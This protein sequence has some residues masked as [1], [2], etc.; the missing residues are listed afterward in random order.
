[1]QNELSAKSDQTDAPVPGPTSLTDWSDIIFKIMT[2]VG[3]ATHFNIPIIDN[4]LEA[5]S[6][7]RNR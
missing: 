7:N 3:Q 2:I 6:M 4:A 1:M 5:Y